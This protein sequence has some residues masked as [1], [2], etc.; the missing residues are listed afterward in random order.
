MVGDVRSPGGTCRG[1]G[2]LPCRESHRPPLT[3]HLEGGPAHLFR[4]SDA[5]RTE[6][7]TPQRYRHG[8]KGLNGGHVVGMS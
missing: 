4:E 6:M 3:Q 5:R 2:P 7:A 1:R 8:I